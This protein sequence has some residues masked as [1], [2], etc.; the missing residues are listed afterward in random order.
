[1]ANSKFVVD[2]GLVVG[3][4]TI[5]AANGD[6]R[7]SGNIIYA[8]TGPDNPITG[9]GAST[10][11]TVSTQLAFPTADYSVTQKIVDGTLTTYTDSTLATLTPTLD[12]FGAQITESPI[13][14]GDTVD[15]Y[16]CMEP[17]GWVET[18]D[19]GELT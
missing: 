1:M 14:S 11:F 10:G 2:T 9:G 5:F 7:T 8:G 19:L 4:L 12:A 16:D 13:A 3:P 17:T 18:T 6:I 15:K